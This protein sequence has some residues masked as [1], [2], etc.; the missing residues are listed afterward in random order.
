MEETNFRI[1]LKKIRIE[2]LLTQE[3]FGKVIGK[4]ITIVNNWEKGKYE[5]S[6]ETL[7]LISQKFNINL[8]WLLLGEGEMTKEDLSKNQIEK[9]PDDIKEGIFKYPDLQK[10]ISRY[11]KVMEGLG[12]QDKAKIKW[13]IEFD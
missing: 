8:N 1:R 4:S 6:M 3:K 13:N 7:I 5:P 12:G 11:L 10:H 9:I 2:K